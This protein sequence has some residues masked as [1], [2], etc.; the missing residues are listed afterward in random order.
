LQEIYS[1]HVTFDEQVSVPQPVEYPKLFYEHFDPEAIAS[2]ASVC[3]CHQ[4]QLQFKK[5]HLTQ[6]R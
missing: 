2:I 3:K 4:T 1:P 5:S 6:K